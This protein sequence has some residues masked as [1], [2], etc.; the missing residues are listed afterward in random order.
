MILAAIPTAVI[1]SDNDYGWSDCNW[2]ALEAAGAP[3]TWSYDLYHPMPVNGTGDGVINSFTDRITDATSRWNVVLS[4]SG[5]SLRLSK[6]TCQA[7]KILIR[8]GAPPDATDFGITYFFGTVNGCALH[9]TANDTLSYTD[10]WINTRPDWF[11]HDDSR[12]SYWETACRNGSGTTYTCN[13]W[14]DFGG[15]FAHEVGHA[16]GIVF[17]PYDVG[18]T[19]TALAQCTVLDSTGRPAY[20]HTMCTANSVTFNILDNKWTSERRTL[21]SWDRESLR[22]V[23]VYH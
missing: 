7:A 12:R 11:T 3:I 15:A 14:Y 22:L 10:I 2:S 13:K 20:R 4:V 16:L 8:Y 18:P 6:V 1:A 19:A 5:T 23:F 21:E 17:H 9:S